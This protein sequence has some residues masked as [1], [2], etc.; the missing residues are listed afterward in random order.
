MR[1]STQSRIYKSLF[2]SSFFFVLIWFAQKN[3]CLRFNHSICCLWCCIAYCSL[4][5]NEFGILYQ[6]CVTVFGQSLSGILVACR[7]VTGGHC[8]VSYCPSGSFKAVFCWS[9][10]GRQGSLGDCYALSRLCSFF[11]STALSCPYDKKLKIHIR[12]RAEAPSV[13]FTLWR[14]S[15]SCQAFICYSSVSGW[16]VFEWSSGGCQAVIKW[17]LCG[18]WVFK[19]VVSRLSC[20]ALFRWID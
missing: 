14:S 16:M 9:F 19:V 11:F 8:A 18:C 5:H 20:Q 12:N 17:S 15:G 6:D 4:T 7:L 2:F 13:L 10:G 1:S 3:F